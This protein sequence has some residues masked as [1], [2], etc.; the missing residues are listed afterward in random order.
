[1]ADM[2]VQDS[3][4]QKSW[5]H[6]EIPYSNQ[7][8]SDRK[9]KDLEVSIPFIQSSSSPARLNFS[10]ANRLL[11]VAEDPPPWISFISKGWSV[12]PDKPCCGTCFANM[13]PNWHAGK[14]NFI[15][16]P[17][18]VQVRF[19]VAQGGSYKPGLKKV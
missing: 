16:S 15:F 10:A 11:A 19:A 3:L 5:R 9:K 14:S 1:M 18:T 8:L 4:L 7:R 13:M 2:L 17:R 6:L 12:D